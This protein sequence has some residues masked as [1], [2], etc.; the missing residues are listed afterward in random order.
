MSAM[1]R[2]RRLWKAFAAGRNYRLLWE[3]RD[4]WVGIYWTWEREGGWRWLSL[5]ICPLPTVVLHIEGRER[6][7]GR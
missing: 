1:L 3:P 2:T 4:L 6:A 5:Y 7:V